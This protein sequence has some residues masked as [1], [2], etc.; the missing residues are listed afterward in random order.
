MLTLRPS[1]YSSS[2]FHP[3]L[4]RGEPTGYRGDIH[5]RGHEYSGSGGPRDYRAGK[6]LE[7]S[8]VVGRYPH[9]PGDKPASQGHVPNAKIPKIPPLSALPGVGCA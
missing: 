9:P 2:F 6:A 5:D 4:R 1:Y 8:Q 7:G 3:L